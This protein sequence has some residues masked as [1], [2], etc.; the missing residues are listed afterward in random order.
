[1]NYK[2]LIFIAMWTG[3]SFFSEI[4]GWCKIFLAQLSLIFKLASWLK[5]AIFYKLQFCSWIIIIQNTKYHQHCLILNLWRSWYYNHHLL[6]ESISVNLVRT[7]V[8][9]SRCMCRG[10]CR[11]EGVF[12]IILA[13][14]AWFPSWFSNYVL[15]MD[16][17]TECWKE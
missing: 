3:Y 10:G 15:P 17:A 6:T 11:N 4:P 14:G 16:R 5:N 8:V 2:S 13:V 7:I 9:W 12:F 1:M